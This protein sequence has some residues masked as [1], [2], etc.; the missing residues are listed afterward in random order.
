MWQRF[1]ERARKIIFYAQE[2]AGQR[3]QGYVGTVDMLIGL[4]RDSDSVAMRIMT[5]LKIDTNALR[6][7]A[8]A[9]APKGEGPHIGD[10]QLTTN[11]KQIIDLAYD[12]ARR[13]D[14]NYIGSEHLLL[15]VLRQNADAVVTRLITDAGLELQVARDQVVAMQGGAI[16]MQDG[17]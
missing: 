8:E 6:R 13:L 10:M 15:A 11:A 7:A 9:A 2:E 14:N 4:L 16:A 1:T 12:E 17:A 3:G 5:R